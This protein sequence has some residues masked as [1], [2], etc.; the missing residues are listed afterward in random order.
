MKYRDLFNEIQL[1]RDYTEDKKTGADFRFNVD[2]IKKQV[3]IE[4]QETKTKLDW[5][6]NIL[7]IPYPIIYNKHVIWVCLGFYLQAHAVYN[8]LKS[9]A[10]LKN[11]ED[12]DW[13]FCGWSLG[14]A[15]SMITAILIKKKR[16]L[17]SHYIGYG[18]PAFV[19]G[20][21]SINLLKT[22]FISFNNF[23]YHG[24]WIRYLVP[25]CSRFESEDII[26]FNQPDNL[27]ARHRVYG[28]CHYSNEG[29]I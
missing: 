9:D 16:K 5:L 8:M 17:K 14:G 11:F 28:K 18:T 7:I 19:F 25:L 29:E 1:S 22:A 20:E 2:F 10:K 27:D 15:S 21:K 24:D 26:P 3:F 13:Y 23:L 4:F 6:F 12:F